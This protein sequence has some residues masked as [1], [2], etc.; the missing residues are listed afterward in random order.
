VRRLCFGEEPSFLLSLQNYFSLTIVD[1]LP[2]EENTS[3]MF[4]I[5]AT[6]VMLNAYNGKTD[7]AF[8]FSPRRRLPM[9][10]ATVTGRS[11]SFTPDRIVARPFVRQ[12]CFG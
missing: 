4:N 3:Q 6:I 5:P 11:A 2:I 10:A 8:C 9:I 12:E 7:I 1:R